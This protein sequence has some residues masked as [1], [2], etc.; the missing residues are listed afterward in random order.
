MRKLCSDNSSLTQ[1]KKAYRSSA[2]ANFKHKEVKFKAK[3]RQPIPALR[4]Y[5]TRTHN[6]HASETQIQMMQVYRVTTW[7]EN[8]FWNGGDFVKRPERVAAAP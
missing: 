3:K 6:V 5:H 8:V 1:L 4:L 2:Q 7:Q